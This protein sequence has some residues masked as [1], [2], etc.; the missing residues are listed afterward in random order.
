MTRDTKSHQLL[1]EMPQTSIKRFGE[2]VSILTFGRDIFKS[3]NLP[4]NQIPNKVI[5]NIY[6]LSLKV[7]NK[8]LRNIDST[9]IITINNHSVLWYPIITQKQQD[10][11]LHKN[12]RQWWFFYHWH[13]WPNLIGQKTNWPI[14]IN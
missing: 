11:L 10:W 8:I 3:Y 12:T 4:F 1:D 7:L 9:G 14:V 6:V 5:S 13:C 2:D